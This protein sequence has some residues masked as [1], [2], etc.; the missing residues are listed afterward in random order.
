MAR[1]RSTPTSRSASLPRSQFNLGAAAPAG[2]LV[3]VQPITQHVGMLAITPD[4]MAA[5]DTLINRLRGST[6]PAARMLRPAAAA[7]PLRPDNPP[8][9]I[10]IAVGRKR[11]SGRFTVEPAITVFVTK[12]ESPSRLDEEAKIPE[13]IDGIPTDVREIG[14]IRPYSGNFIGRTD[15]PVPCG[16]STGTK[17]LSG[18]IGCLVDVGDVLCIL[19]NNHVL[20]DQ[21]LGRV[22]NTL[23]YQPG[24][25]DFVVLRD[26]DEA[27]NDPGDVIG[28]LQDFIPLRGENAVDAALAKTSS[29]A[30]LDLVAPNFPD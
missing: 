21:N 24:A 11:V 20:A 19:S 10:G 12:K 3:R 15:R 28:V 26:P 4:L 25:A 17:Q 27:S 18:T 29:G 1:S 7:G 2:E 8:R 6:H 13:S 30:G 9:V 22:G 5:C 23:I 16:W 14:V